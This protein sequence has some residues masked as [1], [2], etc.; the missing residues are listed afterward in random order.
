[1][2][3]QNTYNGDGYDWGLAGEVCIWGINTMKRGRDTPMEG[4]YTGTTQGGK[5]AVLSE[6]ETYTAVSEGK[7]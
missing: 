5:C 7:T 2:Q 3:Q 1:M 6:G 4:I